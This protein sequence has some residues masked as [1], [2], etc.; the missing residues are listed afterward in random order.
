MWQGLGWINEADIPRRLRVPHLE[1]AQ[2]VSPSSSMPPTC[3]MPTASST[4]A[5]G[6][7]TVLAE[8]NDLVRASG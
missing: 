6:W 3:S 4:G 1:E 8:I 2:R 7:P 5:S